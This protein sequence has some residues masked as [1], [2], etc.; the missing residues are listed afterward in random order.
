MVNTNVVTNT[1]PCSIW[2]YKE[3]SNKCELSKIRSFPTER[4]GS[5]HIPDVPR[6]ELLQIEAGLAKLPLDPLV[7]LSLLFLLSALF[8]L[9]SLDFALSSLSVTVRLTK[10]TLPNIYILYI[11]LTISNIPRIVFFFTESA[12]S[13]H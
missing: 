9:L 6:F 8:H 12:P 3:K 2:I 13:F 11:D 4:L 1:F 5:E 10:Y 7:L